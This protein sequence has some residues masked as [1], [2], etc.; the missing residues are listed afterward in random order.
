MV[1]VISQRI[2]LRSYSNPYCWAIGDRFYPASIRDKS[3]VKK[4]VGIE[5]RLFVPFDLFVG[6]VFGNNFMAIFFFTFTLIL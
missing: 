3:T 6:I 2:S 4:I 5:Q 1:F